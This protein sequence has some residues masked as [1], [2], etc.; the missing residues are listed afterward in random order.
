MKDKKLDIG[1]IGIVLLML[2]GAFLMFPIQA[3][4]SGEITLT[5][6]DVTDPR[7]EEMS[8]VQDYDVLQIWHYSDGRWGNS[9]KTVSD[10]LIGGEIDRLQEE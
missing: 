3:Q 9:T 6:E 10:G 2:V 8:A 7:L 1:I 4:A 5:F